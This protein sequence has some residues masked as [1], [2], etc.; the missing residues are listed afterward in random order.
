MEREIVRTAGGLELRESSGD[1]S[2]ATVVGLLSVFDEWTEIDSAWEG[3]FLERVAPGS[4]LKSI[5]R[6]AAR[7][8]PQFEHGHDPNIGRKVLGPVTALGED[9]RGAF[10]EIA[11]LDTSYNRDL[12]PGL[13]AGLYG[14]SFRGTVEQEMVDRTAMAASHNPKGLSE[15]TVQEV[16]LQDFGPVSF[17]AYLGA[18]A[19]ARS[20][21]D[22][23]WTPARRRERLL[24]TL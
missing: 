6:D 23:L 3:H 14:S 4:F 19:G 5:D 24:E 20:L 21:P 11:L 22:G 8:K 9:S 16:S 12:L 13:K 10:Y 17:P 7:Y 15:R 18:T 2:L 1:G